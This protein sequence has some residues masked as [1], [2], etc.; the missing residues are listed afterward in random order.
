MLGLKGKVAII[1]FIWR[2]C[3]RPGSLYLA[4]LQVTIKGMIPLFGVAAG[5]Q[6][7]YPEAYVPRV[8]F[9]VGVIRFRVPM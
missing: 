1:P 3:R 8:M 4:L 5:A 2:C 9:W 7:L 6:V